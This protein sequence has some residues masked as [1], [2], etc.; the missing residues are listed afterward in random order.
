[1]SK[2]AVDLYISGPGHSGHALP[3]NKVESKPEVNPK[4]D[5]KTD[6]GSEVKTENKDEP[7][8]E[9]TTSDMTPQIAKRAYELYE[10]RGRQDGYADQDW[11][12]AEQEILKNKKDTKD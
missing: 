12:Q 7:K 8:S 10:K 11:N 4:P 6:A 3:E 9:N 5:A 2:D 1:M